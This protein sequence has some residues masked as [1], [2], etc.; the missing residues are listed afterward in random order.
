MNATRRQILPLIAGAVSFGHGAARAQAYPTRPIMLSVGFSAGGGTDLTARVIAEWLS[1]RLG[2]QVVV[3]NRTGMG[4]NLSIETGLK[5]SPDGYTL[6]FVGPNS[7][8]GAS[9]YKNLPF[10]FR[11]DAAPVAFVMHFPNVMLISPSLPAHSVREFIDYAKASSAQLSYAS[12]GNGTS[13]HM[14]GAMFNTMAKINMVHVPY[15][16]A[17]AA[18]PDLISG[19]VHVLFDNIASAMEMVRS[20]QVRAL[21]VTAATRWSTVPDMPTVAETIPGFEAMV[22]YGIVAP[23]GTPAPIVAT[24]NQAIHSGLEDAALVARLAELGGAPKAMSPEEF[25]KFIHADTEKWREVYAASGGFT[26]Q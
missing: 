21:A 10:D 16:G 13:L 24:L 8:I 19:R 26:T 7:T 6:M 12:S 9:I 18:Y 4:G 17:A 22:W 25:E 20:G 1:R 14:C 2:Q 5:A 11:R 15:R 3:E 23:R